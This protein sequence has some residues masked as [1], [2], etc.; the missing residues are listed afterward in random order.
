MGNNPSRIPVLSP[1]L[2]ALVAEGGDA[3]LLRIIADEREKNRSWAE[4]A[5]SE[6]HTRHAAELYVSCSRLCRHYLAADATLAADLLNRVMWRVFNRAEKFDVTK[7][8]C[9]GDRERTTAAVRLWMI[10]QARWM[11]KEVLKGASIRDPHLIEGS[12]YVEAV[13]REDE[14]PYECSAAV[15]VAIERLP[16]RERHIVLAYFFATDGD[17]GGPVQPDE[18]VDVYCARRWG[19]TT[20]YVRKL[21]ER[22]LDKLREYLTPLVASATAR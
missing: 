19:I 16:A 9:G 2:V 14:E 4:A 12:D 7:A 13:G 1:E 22:A 18:S 11:A 6:L 3:D 10:R 8:G 20:D 5:L 15:H 17:T 21:R